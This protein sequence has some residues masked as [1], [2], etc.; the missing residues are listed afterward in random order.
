MRTRIPLTLAFAAVASTAL[1]AQDTMQT[2]MAGHVNPAAL[3][4]WAA[5]NDAPDNEAPA[6]AK[7]RFA[8]ALQGAHDMQAW[9]PILQ[10]PPYTRSGTWN[11]DA[12][13]MIDIAKLGEPAIRAQDGAKAF[14]IGGR[15][16]DACN[17]CHKLYVPRRGATIPRDSPLNKPSA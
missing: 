11:A 17:E 2:I 8:A 10:K 3:A 4:F 5:G 12:Q 13:L 15:L 7:Q 1:A 14:E 6:Q 16:Y 9:G